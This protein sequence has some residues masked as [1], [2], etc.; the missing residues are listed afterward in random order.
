M[1]VTNFFRKAVNSGDV[2]QVRIM[3]KDSLLI[4]TSFNE[5][6]EMERVAGSMRGLYDSHDDSTFEENSSKWNEDYLDMQMVKLISNFSK[7]RISHI[8][9]VVRHLYPVTTN[10]QQH[11]EERRNSYTNNN[12]NTYYTNSNRNTSSTNS[13]KI[14]YIEKK[15]QDEEKGLIL[16][17]KAATGAIAGG[18]VGGIVASAL[19]ATV[20]TGVVIG[21]AVGGVAVVIIDNEVIR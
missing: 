10:K 2:M 6:E 19:S 9:N 18:V 5:S 21:A 13:N 15:K 20:L 14:S 17:V 16:G 8:K 12:K 4:D 11:N 7:E 1:A 3:M